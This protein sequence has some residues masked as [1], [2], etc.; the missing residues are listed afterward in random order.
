MNH[1]IIRWVSVTVYLIPIVATAIY[2]TLK[3]PSLSNNVLSAVCVWALFGLIAT[4][5]IVMRSYRK[6][7]EEER[8]NFI[9]WN[10]CPKCNEYVKGVEVVGCYYC[11]Y[12]QGRILDDKPARS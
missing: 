8:M 2:V 7:D 4:L 5:W 11:G 10:R 6:Q 1:L 12:K 3:T 9:K